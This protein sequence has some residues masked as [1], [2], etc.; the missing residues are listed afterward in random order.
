VLFLSVL[1]I[2]CKKG[3]IKKKNYYSFD[4][5]LYA[6][7]TGGFLFGKSKILRNFLP[8]PEGLE[9][10]D[11]YVGLL[12]AKKY[13]KSY[14]SDKVKYLYRRHENATTSVITKEKQIS[15]IE[16][17]IR[18]YSFMLSMG[19]EEKFI[20]ARKLSLRARLIKLNFDDFLYVI[21]ARNFS[22]KEKLKVIYFQFYKKRL[23]KL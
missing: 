14:V 11:W 4:D 15:L 22:I 21:K 23:Y 1:P 6:N 8:F 7:W 18:F 5:L 16:R 13:E 12:L 10:E 20:K 2:W 17:D 19:V 3:K 9:F